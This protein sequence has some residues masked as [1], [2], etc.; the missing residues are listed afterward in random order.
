MIYSDGCITHGGKT[1]SIKLK[2]EDIYIL[3]ELKRE[4][5]S[6]HNI[7]VYVNYNGYGKGNK[8]GMLSFTNEKFTKFLIKR[9]VCK[10]KS[11]TLEFPTNS[12]VPDK[13]IRH[14][15]RGF[16]DG[17]GSVYLTKNK[18]KA[19]DCFCKIYNSIGFNF[20][21]T[22]SMMKGINNIINHLCET[23]YN[24]NQYKNKNIYQINY[25]GKKLATAFYHYIYD[26][27]TIY[28]KRK[29][30]IFNDFLRI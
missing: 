20:I 10:N 2:S 15:I 12:E 22:Y 13:L 1:F 4:F 28:L 6:D 21:G 23:N 8:Y 9:G 17:D 30:N 5:N 11:N 18:H 19:N 24:I 14:F 29:Y 16:F 7:G 3:E 26:D 25:T 27:A